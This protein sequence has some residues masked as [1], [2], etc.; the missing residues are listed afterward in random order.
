LNRAVVDITVLYD[1]LFNLKKIKF[2]SVF[3]AS[4]Y[5][6]LV[7]FG[8]IIVIICLVATLI[9]A[10][11]DDQPFRQRRCCRRLLRLDIVNETEVSASMPPHQHRPTAAST[12][13]CEPPPSYDEVMSVTGSNQN[14][15]CVIDFLDVDVQS[16][17]SLPVDCSVVDDLAVT[18]GCAFNTNNV[19][20]ERTG[21]A[22]DDW[23]DLTST[24]QG[25][26]HRGSEDD[27]SMAA[28]VVTGGGFLRNAG[29]RFVDCISPPNYFQVIFVSGNL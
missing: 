19:S 13:M 26:P 27:W 9:S 18:S 12:I 15:V 20:V 28:A 29:R 23:T 8:V 10:P 5:A 4:L 24:R 6:G 2:C 1:I 16:S 21:Y 17:C 11:D 3:Q 7:L 25:V 22:R 14:L